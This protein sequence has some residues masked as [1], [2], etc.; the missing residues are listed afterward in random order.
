MPYPQHDQKAAT[1]RSRSPVLDSPVSVKSRREFAFPSLV[2]FWNQKSQQSE[3]NTDQSTTVG[4][5][6]ILSRDDEHTWTPVP[7]IHIQKREASPASHAKSSP[8]KPRALPPMPYS[9]DYIQ[10]T[11]K[12]ATTPEHP[13]RP[14]TNNILQVRPKYRRGSVA[15]VSA[16]DSSTVEGTISAG[17][18]GLKKRRGE[19]TDVV[20]LRRKDW[21][22]RVKGA[23]LIEV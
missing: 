20:K 9:A 6:P 4:S 17:T 22:L 11:W 3:S 18:F 12:R 19:V 23:R 7:D 8:R 13:T 2:D 15:E 16:R 21:R 5:I 14:M 1:V 10:Y